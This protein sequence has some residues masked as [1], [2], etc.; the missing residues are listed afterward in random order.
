MAEP[1]SVTVNGVQTEPMASK[2]VHPMRILLTLTGII[3]LV[4]YVEMMVFPA[5][6]TLQAYFTTSPT[7]ISWIISAFLIVGSI[8]SPLFGRLGD[9][10]GKK[11]MLL[12]SLAFYISGVAMAGFSTSVSMLIFSRALQGIGFS[13]FPLG[14]AIVADVFPR[15]KLA[16]AQ[17]IMSATYGIGAASGLV[18]GS[19][20]VQ[21]FGW[22]WAFHSALIISA[23]LFLII[24][25]V[26]P[27]EGART[28]EK[29]DYVGIPFLMLGATGI[30]LYITEGPTLGWNSP[31]NLVFLAAGI[32]LAFMFFLIES[33]K[34]NP[35]VRVGDLRIRNVFI[36]NMLAVIAGILLQMPALGIM[37]LARSPSPSGFGLSVVS[38][39]LI[40]APGAIAAVVFGPFTGLMTGKQGPKPV[41]L[42]GASLLILSLGSMLLFRQTVLYLTVEAVGMWM[43]LVAIFVPLFN[44][45]V[46]ALPP[47]RRAVGIGMNVMFRN[48]G[49]AL[50]PAVASSLMASYSAPLIIEQSGHAVTGPI[51][52]PTAT[53]Y[54]LIFTVSLILVALIVILS[55]SSKNY[56]FGKV[57]AASAKIGNRMI[58]GVKEEA[59][60]RHE[61]CSE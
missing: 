22:R 4:N 9:S 41:L 36:S 26:L 52:F 58:M 39:G 31:D 48:F 21:D 56:S 15:E 25:A 6:P 32:P 14:I 16:F 20:V 35:L 38:A 11:R 40:I 47:E 57:R 34:A 43:G 30:L 13:A 2:S 8:L 37:Y 46:V 53:A 10:H 60:N 51:L 29:M 45:I 23:I 44:M 54:N 5:M 55:L 49:G 33:R 24:L 50:G 59:M 27:K 17:G 19:Y 28:G 61:E 12:I 18:I 3:L 42:V 1:A 7:T